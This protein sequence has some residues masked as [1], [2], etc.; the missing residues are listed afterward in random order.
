VG[1]R[2]FAEEYESRYA[3]SALANLEAANPVGIAGDALYQLTNILLK[4]EQ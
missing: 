3:N 2:E 4:R 1:A